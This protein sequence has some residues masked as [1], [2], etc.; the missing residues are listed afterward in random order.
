MI[1][2]GDAAG[3]TLTVVCKAE[4]ARIRSTNFVAAE[5]SAD[6]EGIEETARDGTTETSNVDVGGSVGG[7]ITS[8]IERDSPAPKCSDSES[9]AEMSENSLSSCVSTSDRLRLK[10]VETASNDSDCKSSKILAE[11]L[12]INSSGVHY[13]DI[14]AGKKTS[15]RE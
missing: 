5:K 1:G 15:E 8:N 14:A 3:T 11:V 10:G 9:S 2:V 7:S 6:D 12:S 4:A 13:T